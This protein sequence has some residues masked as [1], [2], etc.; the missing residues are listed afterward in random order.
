MHRQLA[1]HAPITVR[2]VPYPMD[3]A[4]DSDEE[5]YPSSPTSSDS[6][7]DE[8]EVNRH[9]TPCWSKYRNLL[10]SRGFKLDTVRDVREY[11]KHLDLDSTNMKSSIPIVLLG[12]DEFAD[13]DALC[14]DAG[15][16]SSSPTLQ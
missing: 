3:P 14:P 5:R 13:D 16:V 2:P 7:F 9:M 11:Y 8:D 15:L 6:S 4:W 1:L 12:Q 10:K